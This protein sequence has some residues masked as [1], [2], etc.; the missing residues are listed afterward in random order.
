M[1]RKI[2]I[3]VVA[4]TL[5]W[6]IDCIA[7]DFSRPANSSI[8]PKYGFSSEAPMHTYSTNERLQSNSSVP[9][10]TS[11]SSAAYRI[12]SISEVS[13]FDTHSLTI[14]DLGDGTTADETLGRRTPRRVI[15][16]GDEEYRPGYDITDPY[17]T[18][19]G[20]VPV[21]LIVML[22]LVYAASIRRCRQR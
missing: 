11:T 19:V 9:F 10:G 17:L 5:L 14:Q 12:Y 2:W 1:I 22:T 7:N 15:S 20:E 21:A 16:N 8:I 6:H 13:T 18:P 4:L 3:W